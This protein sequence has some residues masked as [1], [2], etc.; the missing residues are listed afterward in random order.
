[1]FD[2]QPWGFEDE[3][4]VSPVGFM[5][6]Y[7]SGKEAEDRGMFV[8]VNV[9]HYT[10]AMQWKWAA[11]C[12][13]KGMGRK[14]K[15]YASRSTRIDGRRQVRLWLHKE[16][17]LYAGVLPLSPAHIIGD[18]E[19]GNSLD[20]RVH[21][22][23]VHRNNLHWATPS[24]NRQNYNGIWAMQLRLDFK[25]NGSMRRVKQYQTR[26]HHGKAARSVAEVLDAGQRVQDH[27]IGSGSDGAAECPF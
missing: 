12:S 18:H 2:P 16:L 24:M 20:C 26:G 22:T 25:S 5:P 7:L 13:K 10:W 15:W 19:N 11:V 8:I 6:L 27:S 9:E 4:L 14:E 3:G 1:M 23:L 21:K 17:M